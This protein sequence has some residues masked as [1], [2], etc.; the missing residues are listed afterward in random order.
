MTHIDHAM[1]AH[2]LAALPDH[3]SLTKR[4][5]AIYDALSEVP[6]MS[7]RQ[8]MMRLGF[9]DMNSVRPRVTEMLKSR[10]LIE[11]GERRD[12]V[13]GQTVRLVAIRRK[14]EQLGLL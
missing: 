7:D 3:A 13:T 1:H 10:V 9:T 4:Q 14:P 5:Q 12:T 8:I 11:V 6:A 2:S